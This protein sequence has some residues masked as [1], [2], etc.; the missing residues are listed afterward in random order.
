MRDISEWRVIMEWECYPGVCMSMCYVLQASTV[1]GY[2][3]MCYV[4]TGY[5]R[6]SYSIRS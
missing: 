5:A 2:I 1:T 3:R 6:G 4:V